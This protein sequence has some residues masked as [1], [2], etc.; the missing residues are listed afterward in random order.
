MTKAQILQK[1]I[2]I[3]VEAHK[4]Q[5]DKNGEPY[6]LHPR[7]VM[8]KCR[9]EIDEQIVAVLHDVLEDTNIE[10]TDLL[11]K[12]PLSDSQIEALKLLT[13]NWFG[14]E[15]YSEYIQRIKNSGNN[16]AIWVKIQDLYDNM[17][18]ERC[19]TKKLRSMADKRYWPALVEVKKGW[20]T[21]LPKEKNND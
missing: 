18:P 1:A 13:R 11:C 15:T 12:I 16:I 6:I 19:T 3:A 8:I 14:K 2:E 4:D 9:L 5:L 10:L 21:Q 20:Y 7:R 17:S